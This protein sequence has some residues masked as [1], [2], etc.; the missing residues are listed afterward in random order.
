MRLVK[1]S[2]AVFTFVILS[3]AS[4]YGAA[5]RA[6]SGRLVFETS[7]VTCAP[8]RVTLVGPLGQPLAVTFADSAGNFTFENVEPG[9]YRVSVDI[10]GFERID[11][12]VN[13][14]DGFGGSAATVVV[15]SPKRVAPKDSGGG[16]TI[17]ASEFL[18]GYPKK[19]VNLYKKGVES[20]GKG[21]ADESIK[22]FEQAIDIAPNFYA[23]HNQLGMVYRQAGREQDAEKHFLRAH[24]LNGSDPAPLINLTGLYL[25]ENQPARAVEAGE[26]AVKANSRSAPAFFT[27][28]MALYKFA[29]LD[30]AEAALKRALELAPKMF[31][32]RL[33][34]ANVY[35]KQQR[36][37]NLMEQLDRYLLENPNGDQRAAVEDMRRTLIQSRQD[38]TKV[39]AE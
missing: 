16:G 22:Y 20:K 34:L 15:V 2:V 21:K 31:Q 24:E 9:A 28:G 17:D 8:C 23:A 27:L 11:Q 25:D 29:M 14:M 32:V 33:L 7:G 6:V 36:Y 30:R 1:T 10:D 35:L 37:D 3:V 38:G 12:P 26:Q 18:T 4:T 39:T 5:P 13:F 19:A